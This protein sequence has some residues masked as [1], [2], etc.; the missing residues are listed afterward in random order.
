MLR[1]GFNIVYVPVGPVPP[2]FKWSGWPKNGQ[3]S[4]PIDVCKLSV[5]QLVKLNLVVPALCMSITNLAKI[6][7]LVLEGQKVVRLNRTNRTGGVGP[8]G[9]KSWS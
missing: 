2:Y 5:V 8:D 4:T 7:K 1:F 9:G 6:V 3:L